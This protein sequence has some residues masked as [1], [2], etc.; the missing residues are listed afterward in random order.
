MRSA[1]RVARGV[2]EMIHKAERTV[3]EGRRRLA[4]IDPDALGK[5][6]ETRLLPYVIG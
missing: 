6:I 4:Q 5:L 2:S 1:V 3:L